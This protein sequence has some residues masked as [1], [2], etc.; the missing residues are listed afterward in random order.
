MIGANLAAALVAL[1]AELPTVPKNQCA[2]VPTKAGGKY[3]YTYAGLRDVTEAIKPLLAKRDLAFICR[4][5]RADDGSAWL[6][7]VLLHATGEAIDGTLP[8]FG[9]QAQEI[10]S[11]IT[12][13]RR[14]LL[15]VLTGV[16]TDDDDDGRL[17]HEVQERARQT[18]EDKPMTPKTRAA[19]FAAMAEH[20]ELAEAAA[21]RAFMEHTLGHVVSSRGDL[22]EGEAVRLGR[23]LRAWRE[24]NPQAAWIPPQVTAE[25]AFP[26]EATS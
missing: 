18:V 11:S 1:Q 7:G 15:G 2:E 23:R 4:P 3:T 13:G 24:G 17:A 16:I 12:Y 25:D 14:Y 19:L 8:L 9:R 22:T 6:T 5:E 10:G 26:T 21:Q 20:P